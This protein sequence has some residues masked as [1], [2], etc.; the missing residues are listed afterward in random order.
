MDPAVLKIEQKLEGTHPGGGVRRVRLWL[1][2]GTAH[3]RDTA[4]M[5][6]QG[7]EGGAS[8]CSSLWHLLLLHG[9][10]LKDDTMGA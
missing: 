7:R 5:R 10:S 4:E 6:D 8:A 9:F 1:L 3:V 2:V